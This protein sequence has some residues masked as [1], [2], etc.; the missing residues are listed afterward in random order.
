MWKRKV[1][2]YPKIASAVG[3]LKLAGDE[4]EKCTNF[5][6]DFLEI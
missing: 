1:L 5:R 3:A 2:K 4:L 6:R